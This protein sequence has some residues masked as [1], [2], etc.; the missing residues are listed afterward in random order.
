MIVDEQ[1]SCV[2]TY[3]ISQKLKIGET[4]EVGSMM[5]AKKLEGEQVTNSQK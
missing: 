1:T 4:W 5:S 2:V 3:F